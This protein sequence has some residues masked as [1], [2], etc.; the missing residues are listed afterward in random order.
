[1]PEEVSALV[2]RFYQEGMNGGKREAARGLCTAD[3]RHHD[4]SLGGGKS[5]ALT[6]S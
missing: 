6:S 4:P 2:M 5:K 1:M 3:Y